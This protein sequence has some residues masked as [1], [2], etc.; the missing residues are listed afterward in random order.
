MK[1]FILPIVLQIMGL[2]V[3]LAEIFIPSLGVLAII[4][5]GLISYSLYLVFTTI[6]N[7]SGMVFIGLD[8]MILPILVIFGMRILAASP[9]SLKNRLSSR[10]G[11][12]SQSLSLE[13][14]MDK[15]GKALTTLRPSGAALIDGHRLDVVTDGD[16]IEAQT[17]IIVIGVT[18]NQII[19][20]KH[21]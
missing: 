10:D 8:I 14:Y 16:F 12:I 2:L 5:L 19:V 4:A 1:L 3:I 18:G 11:V 9:L 17:P 20:A 21:K 6:S 15:Q 13:T 7:F